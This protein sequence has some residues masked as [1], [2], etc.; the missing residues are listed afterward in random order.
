MWGDCH[1]GKSPDLNQENLASVYKIL[2]VKY[3]FLVDSLALLIFGLLLSWVQGSIVPALNV[4][5]TWEAD[6]AQD[7]FEPVESSLLY[8][9]P[10]L[11]P[12]MGMEKTR[13]IVPGKEHLS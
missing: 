7:K 10:S 9:A 2:K 11:V 8:S 6:L 12:T 4:P 3:K 13:I 1:L 5:E